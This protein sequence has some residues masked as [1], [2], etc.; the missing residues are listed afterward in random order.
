[1]NLFLR[2]NH[3][4]AI[5]KILQDKKKR[6]EL[7]KRLL[8]DNASALSHHHHQHYD[9]CYRHHRYLWEHK[10]VDLHSSMPA[11]ILILVTGTGYPSLRVTLSLLLKGQL[12]VTAF[13]WHS[14]FLVF[15]RE[16]S[17]NVL[18]YS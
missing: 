16:R 18:G 3:D 6:C 17:K 11:I 12:P 1:M 13:V 9:H 14:L 15:S 7:P 4:K 2:I 5:N 8:S 10:T